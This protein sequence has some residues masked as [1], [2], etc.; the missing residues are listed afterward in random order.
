MVADALSNPESVNERR[1]E[2]PFRGT[3]G[4]LFFVQKVS[5]FIANHRDSMRLTAV[6]VI[7]ITLNAL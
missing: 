1:L 4:A 2:E 3:T 5:I 6:Y 7:V